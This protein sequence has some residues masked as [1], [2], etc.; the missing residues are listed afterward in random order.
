[1]LDKSLP[2]V[3]VIMVK[4]DTSNYPRY[5]LPEGYVFSGYKKGFEKQW[6]KIQYELEQTE[7][8]EAAEKIWEKEYSSYPE[9]LEQ[10]CIFVLTEEGEIAAYGSLWHGEHF[11]EEFQRFHWIATAPKFQGK[12]LI[13]AVLTKILDLYNE[14]GYKDFI[15]LTSQTWSIKALNLYKKY[16]FEP[17]LGEK[18]KN[19]VMENFEETSKKAWELIE[20]KISQYY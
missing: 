16:G 9:L 6:A 5:E 11:G 15:Y 19:W 3:G 20:E 18:P 12:G 17:Y 13:K 7:T 2:L 14:L 8:L 4:K 10:K 1:M